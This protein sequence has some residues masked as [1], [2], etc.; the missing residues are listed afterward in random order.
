M[1]TKISAK[2]ILIDKNNTTMVV[3]LAIAAFVTV[4][5]VFACKALLNQRA[6]QARVITE[7]KKSLGQLKS[8]NKAASELINSYKVFISS[9]ENIIKGNASGTA[10][11]DGD[12]AKIILDALPSKY[13]FPALV[14]SLDK[15]FTSPKFKISGINGSDDE[16]KQNTEGATTSTAPIEIP[17]QVSASGN[18]E[19]VQ[20]LSDIM[21]RSIRP[22]KVNKLSINGDDENLTMSID[23]VTY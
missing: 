18:F 23:A 10:D 17:F 11:K 16:L 19:G 6:Y 5:S 4:F 15:L 12:S 1:S 3:A 7:K 14:T 2:R 21:N 22:I 13:D 20:S 9:P 8:N